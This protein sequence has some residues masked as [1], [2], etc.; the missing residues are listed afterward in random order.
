[1]KRRTPS[2]WKRLIEDQAA[3]GLS[4]VAFCHEHN[5]NPKYFSLRKS[6]LK[7]ESSH[8]VKA[9]IA[10]QPVGEI[11]LKCLGVTMAL[12]ANTSPQWIAQLLRELSA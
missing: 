4:A 10:S 2:D 1:M 7:S 8:F 9:S 5:L 12:P 3:S 6:Q 11:T